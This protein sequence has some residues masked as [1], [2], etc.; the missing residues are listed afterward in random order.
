MKLFYTLRMALCHPFF[1][2]LISFFA[3]HNAESKNNLPSDLKKAYQKSI[4]L[5][6]HESESILSK[7]ESKHP[8]KLLIEDYNDA[9]KLLIDEDIYTFDK[10]QKKLNIRLKHLEQYSDKNSPWFRFVKAE[11]EFHWAIINFKFNNTFTAVWKANKA[12]SLIKENQNK[13]PDFNAN[14]KTIGIFH[15]IFGLLP[16]SYRWI[17]D[18]LGF[19]GDVKLGLKELSQCAVSNSIVNQES[20]IILTYFKAH[21][22]NEYEISRETF[23]KMY[24]EN[25]TLTLNYL[26]VSLYSNNHETE[27]AIELIENKPIKS[28]SINF[29]FYYYKLGNCLF[30]KGEYQFAINAFTI[31]VNN[32]KGNNYLKGAYHKLS[33]AHYFLNHKK[34]QNEALNLINLKGWELFDED[35]Y[36]QKFYENKVYPN[37]YL[38]KAR[39]FSDGGYFEKALSTLLEGEKTMK[40]PVEKMELNYRFARIY[41]LKNDHKKALNFYYKS[42]EDAEK[43]NI[44]NEYFAPNSCLKAALIHLELSNTVEAQRLLKKAIAYKNH[45]YE[46]SIEMKAKSLLKK[47]Q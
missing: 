29:Y 28:D 15:I 8:L 5:K 23:K 17:F 44:E 2:L 32:Y 43:N 13:F 1:I 10:Y 42:I 30:Q 19:K 45:E 47:L 24:T 12:Y 35:K 4:E 16:D 3:F 40:T 31:F 33:L 37:I 6:L 38:A 41:D 22:F 20:K 39:Y 7:S 11:I 34:E 21:L 46:N 26:L 36:A 18:K 14:L 27:K 9:L 25:E